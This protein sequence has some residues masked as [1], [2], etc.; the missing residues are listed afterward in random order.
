VRASSTII[1]KALSTCQTS[2]DVIGYEMMPNFVNYCNNHR[3]SL[4]TL[5]QMSLLAC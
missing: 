2:L 1:E 4:I 3:N 5:I